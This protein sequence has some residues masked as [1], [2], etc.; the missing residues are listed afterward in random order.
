MFPALYIGNNKSTSKTFCVLTSVIILFC[1]TFS[2]KNP[3]L[4]HAV[5]EENGSLGET[6]E[7]VCDCQVDDENVGRRPQAPAPVGKAG[8]CSIKLN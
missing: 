5:D 2:P 3:S 8:E 6:H 4:V 1:V 7:E